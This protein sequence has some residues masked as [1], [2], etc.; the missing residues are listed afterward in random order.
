VNDREVSS[1]SLVVKLL[2]WDR[3]TRNDKLGYF[4]TPLAKYPSIHVVVF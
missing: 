4:W 3:F 1:S 2:D